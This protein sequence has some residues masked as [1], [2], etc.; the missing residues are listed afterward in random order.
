MRVR[1]TA[2]AAREFVNG[3]EYLAQ[4]APSIVAEF[5]DARISILG[6]GDGEK[7]RAPQICS[8]L[9]L[10]RFL[11]GRKRRDCRASH[12]ARRSATALGARRTMTSCELT[13]DDDSLI[14]WRV[15]EKCMSAIA[16]F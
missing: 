9:P 16:V 5:A 1:Y 2:T 7:G 8:T 4:H 14:A 3:I 15:R 13:C 11:C 6:S 12:Q 10:L